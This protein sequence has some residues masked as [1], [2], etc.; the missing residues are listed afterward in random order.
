MIPGARLVSHHWPGAICG[1]RPLHI[2]AAQAII[3]PRMDGSVPTSAAR[4]AVRGAAFALILLLAINMFNYVDRYVLVAVEQEIARA[5]FPG[6][7]KDV[8]AKTGLLAT[9]FLVSYLLTSPIFGFLADRMSRWL[10]VGLA[11]I[12]WSAATGGS[13]L[14][15]TF[16]IM[17]V[18]RMFVGI[19]E[20][21]YGPAAPTII[22]DLYPPQKRA[23]ILAWFYMAIPV[24]SALG[25]ILGGMVGEQ[26]GWRWAFFVVVPPGILLGVMAL[27]MRD[28]APPPG[29]SRPGR[30]TATC[31][32]SRAIC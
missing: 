14:A 12:L 13:G 28:P 2:G 17:L 1:G 29:E 30:I 18:T 15:P 7:T 8:L 22:A 4:P 32:A 5:Y 26:W 25:Y 16:G 20:A 9:A 27:F 11:V 31:S 23:R 21:G 6:E 10:L 19:G 24:G 3:L